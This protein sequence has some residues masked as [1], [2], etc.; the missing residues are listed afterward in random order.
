MFREFQFGWRREKA[1]SFYF[2]RN[3]KNEMCLTVRL[4]FQLAGNVFVYDFVACLSTKVSKYITGR[5][6]ARTFVSRL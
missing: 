4:A 6:S 3:E 5:K 2:L 1:S